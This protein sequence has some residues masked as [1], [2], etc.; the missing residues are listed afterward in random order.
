MD[1]EDSRCIVTAVKLRVLLPVEYIPSPK[2]RGGD[3]EFELGAAVSRKEE[4]L[5]D[6]DKQPCVY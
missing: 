5:G 6:Q 2:T 3:R 1:E 4:D